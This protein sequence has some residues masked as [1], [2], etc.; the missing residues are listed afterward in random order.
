MSGSFELTARCDNASFLLISELRG[1]PEQD[2]Q[3]DVLSA[4]SRIHVVAYYCFFLWDPE[5]RNMYH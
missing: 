3:L 4:N 5:A 2:T 1:Y